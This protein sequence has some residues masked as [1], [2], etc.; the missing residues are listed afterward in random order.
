MAGDPSEITFRQNYNNSA[1]QPSDPE[2]L[3][4]KRQWI[5]A[6]ER[7]MQAQTID[8]LAKIKA[9]ALSLD[10]PTGDQ[11]DVNEFNERLNKRLYELF[12]EMVKTKT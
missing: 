9:E 12:I 8:E 5:V 7:A 3:E 6:T 1:E 2:N 10:F 11:T 4:K